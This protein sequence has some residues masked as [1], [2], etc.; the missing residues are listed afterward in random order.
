MI[1]DNIETYWELTSHTIAVLGYI[2]EGWMFYR[3]VKPFMKGKAYIVGVSYFITMLVFY[4]IPQEVTYPNLQGALVA[5]ITMCLLEKRNYRQKVFLAV[6][7]YLF[8]WMVYGVTLVLRDLMFT[9][10]INTPYMLMEPVKQWIAYIIVEFIYYGIALIV[11]YLVIK[12]IHKVYVNKKEDISGKELLLLLAT[13]M[14]VMMG[15]FTFNFVSNVYVEDLGKYVWNVHPE[16]TLLRVIYQMV[17]FAAILIAIIIY[18][19]L[20]ETQREEKENILLAE[21]IENTKQ[22]IREVEKLYEDIRALKHDMGNHIC[23]LENLFRKIETKETS[24]VSL[25]NEEMEVKKYLSELKATFCE[26]V[27]EIKTGNPVTD[28]ILTQKQKEA[29]EK[30]IDLK[31]KFSYPVDSNINAFD[32]SVI[33]NNAIE[34]A[35]EGTMG[36]ESP[37]V[38][39]TAYRRKNAYMIEVRNCISKY[40]EIDDETGFPETTKKDKASHGFGLSNIRKVAQKYHGDMDIR[41]E[42]GSFI[43]TVMLMVN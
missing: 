5:G 31:C 2:A 29:E 17:S 9:L 20:Q 6:C 40:V 28:V 34:N 33:L 18:Q 4:G 13:L 7:M 21:Q 16:Y 10:V 27:A 38:S 37:Y 25:G 11:M 41:Q 1:L 36:C 39:I 43:L 15:Y 12:L 3:F 26:S 42:E 32:I 22:H 8:R 24:A 30:E 19:K 23:V 35:L 14:T